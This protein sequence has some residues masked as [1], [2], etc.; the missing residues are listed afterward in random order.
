MTV[1]ELKIKFRLGEECRIPAIDSTCIVRAIQID[2]Q[3]ISF[4]VSYWN[5][6]QFR[7]VWLWPDELEAKK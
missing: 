3:G 7:E 4:K 5:D 2:V 1:E 6:C